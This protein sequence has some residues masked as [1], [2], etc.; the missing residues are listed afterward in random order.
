MFIFV[1]L[2]SQSVSYVP[3]G[4]HIAI[5]GCIKQSSSIFFFFLW[6]CGEW[7]WG[8]AIG[9][10]NLHFRKE[11]V[12]DSFKYSIQKKTNPREVFSIRSDMS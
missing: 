12:K 1:W 11:T 4:L 3:L 8:E 5:D 10:A 2:G 7:L 6:G 9:F